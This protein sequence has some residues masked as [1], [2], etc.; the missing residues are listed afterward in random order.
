M[1]NCKELLPVTV[2]GARGLVMSW[3]LALPLNCA[4]QGD[5]GEGSN[6]QPAVQEDQLAPRD[7]CTCKSPP[8][9][10]CW[11]VFVPFQFDENQR[12]PLLFHAVMPIVSFVPGCP[13][14][15]IST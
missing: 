7:Q 12:P 6:G 13:L 10:F 9:S 5:V 15:V 14:S 4:L 1:L 2:A 8:P 11:T 3:M